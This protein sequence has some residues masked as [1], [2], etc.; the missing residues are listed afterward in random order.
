M[1]YV[2]LSKAI[3]FP[4]FDEKG[5]GGLFPYFANDQPAKF[6]QTVFQR[7]FKNFLKFN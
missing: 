2:P 7:T 1:N 6:E 4:N 3:Y 5:V